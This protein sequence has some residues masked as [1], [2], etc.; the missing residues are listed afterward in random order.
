MQRTQDSFAS[1]DY[2]KLLSDLQT[3]LAMEKVWGERA[4]NHIKVQIIWKFGERIAQEF[5]KQ[6]EK[7]KYG[8]AL[9]IDL[10]KDLNISKSHLFATVK[11]FFCY[12]LPQYLSPEL[13]W[14]HYKSLITIENEQLR[15]FYEQQAIANKWSVRDLKNKIQS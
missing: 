15:R 7:H 1:L 2:P 8:N 6:T 9:Y 13:S 5:Q 14:T 11:F 10:A 4:L 12:P 3:I